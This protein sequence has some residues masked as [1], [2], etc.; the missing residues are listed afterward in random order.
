MSDTNDW[1]R[2]WTRA[3]ALALSAPTRRPLLRH[4]PA[5]TLLE[6]CLQEVVEREGL[7]LLGW[8]IVPD[9]LHVVGAQGSPLPW[10]CAIGRVKQAFSHR[11]RGERWTGDA[12]PWR[13][14]VRVRPLAERDLPAALAALHDLPVRDGLCAG[15]ADWR[16]SSARQAARTPVAA[17][18]QASAS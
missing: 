7:P 16:W 10:T 14:D 12:P 6:R 11:A 2:A 17:I 4:R 5:A 1:T 3:V 9:G 8:V 13:L 18:A 15:P